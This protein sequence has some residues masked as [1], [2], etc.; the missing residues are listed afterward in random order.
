MNPLFEIDW[1]SRDET[2]GAGIFVEEGIYFQPYVSLSSE[3]P[4]GDSLAVQ[5]TGVVGALNL[6]RKLSEVDDPPIIA[7]ERRNSLGLEV[8]VKKNEADYFPWDNI[9]KMKKGWLMKTVTVSMKN[10][11]TLILKGQENQAAFEFI[12]Q[13]ITKNK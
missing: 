12:S 9:D 4:L 7:R 11:V 10:G 1:V 6:H 2:K 8:L 13:K 5:A 3:Y